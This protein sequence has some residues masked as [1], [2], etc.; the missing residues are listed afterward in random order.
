MTVAEIEG[1]AVLFY[2][3]NHVP[4]PAQIV[5]QAQEMYQAFHRWVQEFT[6]VHCCNCSACQ[7]IAK[8]TL[9]VVAHAGPL[10][11]TTVQQQRKP[12]GT[13]VVVHR[14]LK[15]AIPSRE[16]VLLTDDLLTQAALP[17]LPAAA[18]A[19]HEVAFYEG[20]GEVGYV[21]LLLSSSPA[22]GLSALR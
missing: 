16:Y 21:H 9:K 22:A 5:A 18:E 13:T 11:F 19:P 15:N 14:L 4:A 6:R 7:S 1:D 12:F 17:A 8:L 3:E 20:V 10:G 2:K